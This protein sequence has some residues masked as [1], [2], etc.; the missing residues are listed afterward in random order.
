MPELAESSAVARWVIT[1]GVLAVTI[2][3][4]MRWRRQGRF[5]GNMPD[6]SVPE[7]L[8]TLAH[9]TPCKCAQAAR[10][11]TGVLF[12][13]VQIL[14]EVLDEARG[15][16]PEFG[17]RRSDGKTIF[18][19][20]LNGLTQTHVTDDNYDDVEA[21]ADFLLQCIAYDPEWDDSD[22]W[23]Q[24]TVKVVEYLTHSENACVLL[25]EAK[26]RH[27]KKPIGFKMTILHRRLQGDKTAFDEAKTHP[28][29]PGLLSMNTRVQCPVCLQMQAKMVLCPQCCNVAYCS[30]EHQDAD[31]SR[32]HEWCFPPL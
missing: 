21:F 6:I 25:E 26:E 30:K 28:S 16:H 3:L 11:L 22:E 19:A 15:V 5:C 20:V 13:D 7:A 2:G 32:H 24:L 4:L 18:T 23:N 27:K 10:A 31:S 14:E 12:G 1:A 8:H 9:G 29:T 17:C